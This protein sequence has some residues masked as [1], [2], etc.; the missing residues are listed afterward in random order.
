MKGDNFPGKRIYIKDMN[1]YKQ[2]VKNIRQKDLDRK[3]KLKL[4]QLL[5]DFVLNDDSILDFGFHIRNELTKDQE[6]MAHL[7]DSIKN[8][9]PKEAASGPLREYTLY[10]FQRIF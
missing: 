2:L 10:I 5:N 4:I 3:I 7:I 6:T 8:S 1:G 9:N